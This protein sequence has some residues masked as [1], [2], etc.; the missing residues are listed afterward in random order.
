LRIDPGA[1]CPPLRED[2]SAD[3]RIVGG[4]FSG[5]WTA[6]ESGERDPSLEIGLLEVHICGAGGSG[7]NG[8]V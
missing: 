5:L 8:G 1:P 2:L 4:G 3:V 7:A 6:Y